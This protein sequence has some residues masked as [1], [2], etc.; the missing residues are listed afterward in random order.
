MKSEWKK[1]VGAEDLVATVFADCEWGRATTIMK[2]QSLLMLFKIIF[3]V[4]QQSI[5]K[6]AV[7]CEKGAIFKVDEANFS[8]ASDRFSLF[9]EGDV[10]VI[11]LC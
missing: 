1:T 11:L 8:L 10:G 4:L 5:G 9:R 6:I 3:D 7:T 2:K